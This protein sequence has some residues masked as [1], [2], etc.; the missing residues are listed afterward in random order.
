[1][2]KFALGI[3][4]VFILLGGVL[5]AA[6]ERKISLT[7]LTDEEIV[8]FTND[9]QAENYGSDEIEVQLENST[10]GV[11]AEIVR[12]NDVINP[13]TVRSLGDNRYAI[14]VS[15][16]ENKNSGEAEVK[17][18]ARDDDSQSV[19]VYVQVNTIIESLTRKSDDNVDAR[20]N[21]F[22]VKGVEKRLVLEDYFV[23][24]PE[25]ANVYNIDWTI[26]D[27]N[28]N[29][30]KQLL[31]EDVVLAEIQNDR[32]LVNA[33]YGLS[34]ITIRA[35]ET[36]KGETETVDFE[37]LEN[38]TINE[39]YMDDAGELVYLYQNNNRLTDQ[40]GFELVRNE[41]NLSSVSGR[42]RVNTP[43]Q[44][45][46]QPLVYG[47]NTNG[48]LEMVSN[49]LDYFSFTI[50]NT[51]DQDG[52]VVYDFL[53]DA[54]DSTYTKNV[55]GE[56]VLF[57]RVG[58]V[59][60]N[61]DVMTGSFNE[62]GTIDGV[63]INLDVY[64][65][66]TGIDL[67]NQE[68]NIINN[69]SID[70]FSD[71]VDGNGYRIV[72]TLTP[73][74][75][76][77]EGKEFYISVNLNQ[78]SLDLLN[79]NLAGSDENPIDAFAR[80]YYRNRL[81]EFNP[82]EQGSEVYVTTPI[83]DGSTIYVL[84]SAEMFEVLNDVTFEFVSTG[85]S[86]AKTQV[87]MNFYEVSDQ[88]TL[89][90]NFMNEDE[91]S[92]ETTVFLP[93]DMQSERTQ[94][95]RVRIDGISTISG[96]TLQTDENSY[97]QFSDLRVVDS[98]NN[99][100]ET[101]VI[102]EFDVTLNGY[103]FDDYT[104]FWFE[105]I[106]GRTSDPLTIQAF[107][108]LD[109]VFV[110]N[111]EP[112][113]ADV[114]KSETAS[115]DFVLQDDGTI[116]TNADY[117]NTSLSKLMME[118]GAMLALNFDHDNA[119]LAE[120][121]SF[122][123]LPFQAD[124]GNDFVSA[125][126]FINQIGDDEEALALAEQMFADNNLSEIVS[127]YFQYF[128]NLNELGENYFTIIDGNLSL[129]DKEFKGFL[130]VVFSGYNHA[131]EQVSVVRFFALE[132]FYS[133]RYL[134]SS[135][136]ATELY[137]S[138]T[139]SYLDMG[140]SQVNVRIELRPDE[141]IPT[142]SNDLSF[143]S[144]KSVYAGENY[145]GVDFYFENGNAD[146][147]FTPTTEQDRTNN[148][149]YTLSA[150]SFSGSGRYLNFTITANSTNMQTQVRD[151]LRIVYRDANGFE[152]ETE[153][154]ISIKNV[155]RIESVECSDTEVY[156]NLTSSQES[157]RSYTITTILSPSDANDSGLTY[158]Y[159]AIGG[160][161]ND[162]AITTSSMGQTFSLNI[163]TDTASYG[164]L[165]L[166]PNDMIKRYGTGNHILLYKYTED[167]NGKIVETALYR[168]LSDLP[169]LYDALVADE[170]NEEF[171]V[172]FLNND[173][174]KIYYKDIV[175]RI[176]VT[177]ADGSS[178]GTAIRVYSEQ[179][180]RNIDYAKY[181]Q[182]MNNITLS[183]WETLSAHNFSGMLFGND[184][185][186][187]LTFTNNSQVFMDT[188]DQRGVIRDLTFAGTV[189][190]TT[191]QTNGGFVAR[192]NNGLIENVTIDVY[193][194]RMTESYLGST[195]S[196]S[197]TNVGGIVG[198]NN[199]TL[200]DCNVF[201]LN[202][203]ASFASNNY[204]GGLA[205]I[206]YN[207]IQGSGVEFYNFENGESNKFVSNGN[208]GIAGGLAGYAETG[209]SISGSYVYAYSLADKTGDYSSS[210]VMSANLYRGAFVGSTRGGDTV[211]E[212]FAFVGDLTAPF[213]VASSGT[214]SNYIN[215]YISYINGG[216][217]YSRIFDN[218]TFAY[219]SGQ[220]FGS[221]LDYELM[222][223]ADL[224][225]EELT[226][227]KRNFIDSLPIDVW[228]ING[229]DDVNFGFMYLTNTTQTMATDV[230][231]LTV[232]DNTSPMKS[233]YV[234]ANQGILFVYRTTTNISDSAQNSVLTNL[235]TLS[236]AD[237]FGITDEQA[238]SLLLT[239]DSTN[240]VFDANYIRV[241]SRTTTPF[242]VEIHSKM[243]YSVSKTFQFVILNNLPQLSLSI[244]GL[245]LGNNQT[246]MLQKGDLNTRNVVTYLDSSIY[247]SGNPNPYQTQQD[248]YTV[249][250]DVQNGNASDS[251]TYVRVIK[252]GNNLSLTG[253]NNHSGNDV[254]YVNPYVTVEGLADEYVQALK[255]QTERSFGVSVYNG[256]TSLTI[257]DASDLTVK[258]A[259][260]AGFEVV[261][262][263]DNA[264]DNLVFTLDYHLDGQTI[265]ITDEDLTD[266][267]AQF[268]VD[269]SL[270]LEVS[271]TKE[272][273]AESENNYSF[274]SIISVSRE[275]R[276]LVNK[277]YN[278]TLRINSYS[279]RN[280]LDF[281]KSIEF[282]VVP[283][284][285]NAIGISVYEIESTQIRNSIVY[286]VPSN[287]VTNVLSPSS[288]AILAVT[289][290]PAYA[291]ASRFTLTYT[292][293]GSGEVGTVSIARLLFNA[294]Y[295][296]YVNTTST[297]LIQNGIEVQLTEQDKTGDGVYYFRIRISGAFNTNSD[298]RFNVTYYNGST[299]LKSVDKS[300]NVDYVQ[301]ADIKVNGVSTYLMPRGSQATVTVQIGLDQQLTEF[302]L[303]GNSA[304]ISLVWNRTPEIYS[305]YQIYTATLTA[306]VNATLANGK[307]NGVFYVN[308]TVVSTTGL[309]QTPKTSFATVCLVDF[310]VDANNITVASSGGTAVYNGNTYDVFYSYIGDT[311][312]LRFDYPLLPEEYIYN[313]TNVDEVQK[314]EE[315]ERKKIDFLNTNSYIDEDAEYY[316]NYRRNS[317]T[318]QYEQLTLK[319]QLWYASSE[320]SS[321]T[322]FN[323]T[324]IIQNDRF[325]I[326]EQNGDLM[327][328]GQRTGRQLM[329]LQTIVS[330]QGIEFVY[331][332][333]FLIVV[334]VW[335]D[336]EAPTQITTGA[337]F[338]EFATLSEQ[339]DDYIL[340]N[341][342][343]LNE[344]TPINT[345]LI[346]S[347][348]GNGFTI[349]INSFAMPEGNA[350]NLA[351]FNEVTENTTLKNVRVNVHQGGHINVDVSAATGYSTINI[352]G[353]ALT[354]NGIIYNCEVV[355]YYDQE[356]QTVQYSTNGIVVT[357]TLGANTDPINLTS[358]MGVTSMVSGFVGTNN[359]S[360]MNSRV[361]G[362]SFRHVVDIGGRDYL[363]TQQ[364]DVFVLDG[365]GEVAGFV[366][367]NG[368]TVVS[369]ETGV[370]D[371]T[372]YISAS[373]VDN[374]QIYNRMEATTSTTAGFVLYNFNNI[375]GSYIEGQGEAAEVYKNLTNIT[376]MGIV[377][378][379]VYSND[380]LV[381][382]SYAN[383]AIENSSSRTALSA[384]FVYMNN[385]TGEVT[386]CYAACDIS[387]LDISE[388][389]FSG[390]NEDLDSLNL[391]TISFCYYYNQTREELT[392][393]DRIGSGA[394]PVSDHNQDTFY[395]FNFASGD[396]T[397]DGIWKNTENGITLVSANTIALSNRNPVVTNNV[398]SFFYSRSIADA[399]TLVT[400]DLSYGSENN[401]IIIR[402]AEEFAMATGRATDTEISSYKEYYN[403]DEVFGNYRL[404]NNI[405]LSEIDQNAENEGFV[406]LRTT[407][408]TFSGLL[409]G[410]G[411]SVLNLNLGSSN[412]TESYGLFARLENAVIMNIDFT[413]DTVHNR[414]ANVVGALAG[415]AID[416]RLLSINV[417]PVGNQSS[418]NTY[419]FGS[420]VVGG[421][422]GMIFGQSKMHD[423]NVRDIEIYSSYNGQEFNE[424]DS[425]VGQPLR[426]FI[427]R[428]NILESKI[429]RISY[430]GAIAGYVDIY[431]QLNSDY[432]KFNQ[433]L[434]V[435]DFNVVTV[436]VEDAIDI[437]GG[438]AGGLFGYVG[439][440]TLIYDAGIEL[441]A[442]MNLKRPSY[443]ISRNL[444]AGGLIGENYG[445]L[446]AVYARYEDELQ[447]TIE[448]G[449][450]GYYNGKLNAEKGQQSIFS[451]TPNDADY[452]TNTNDPMFV[453]GLVGYMGGGYIYVGYNK[454]NVI[455]HSDNTYAVGGVIGFAA[456]NS[457]QFELNF[458]TSQP[459][460]NILLYDVY[461]SGDVYADGKNAV[462]AGIVGAMENNGGSTVLMGM[463]DV[464]AVNYYTY[465]G[466]RFSGDN[467]GSTVSSGSYQGEYLSDRHFTVIG[468]IL[469][470]SSVNEETQRFDTVQILNTNLY[471]ISS[472]DSMF[473]VLQATSTST[474]ADAGS[475][476]VGGYTR[477]LVGQTGLNLNPYG[478]GVSWSGNRSIYSNILRVDSIGDANSSTMPAAYARMSTYF[479]PIGWTDDYWTHEENKL[480]PE[481]ELLPTLDILYWDVK[482]T[483]DG[484][485]DVE[486]QQSMINQIQQNPFIT[487]VL[488]G[489]V[490]YESPEEAGTIC[491]DIDL[492]GVDFDPIENFSGTLISYYEYTNTN[493][494]GTVSASEMS[495]YPGGAKVS[496][497]NV[498][499]I[500]DQPLFSNLSEGAIIQGVKFYL[501][502]GQNTINFS[503]VE[504]SAVMTI[505]RND[506]IILNNNVSLK[507]RT[508]DNNEYAGLLVPRAEDTSIV[509]LQVKF[510]ASE[511]GSRVD[512]FNITA[513]S[514]ASG[515]SNLYFGAIVG[516]N[517]QGSSTT[518]VSM[519]QIDFVL[520][521]EED[522]E[523]YSTQNQTLSPININFNYG[524]NFASA[525]G[526]L[527]AG[528]V[529]KIGGSSRISMGL[530]RVD[531][532][533]LNISTDTN[534]TG[535]NGYFGG[536][537]GS[538]SSLDSLTYSAE[539][540][541]EG[542]LTSGITV[543]QNS[544]FENLY[545]GL[546][547]GEIDSSTINI[548]N[549]NARDAI[550]K[551]SIYQAN[552]VS[553]GLAQIGGIA[554]SVSNGSIITVQGFSIDLNVSKA[555]EIDETYTNEFE[556]V[557]TAYGNLKPYQVTGA[558]ANFGGFF[559]SVNN[560]QTTISGT[561]NVTGYVDVESDNNDV[562]FA[563]GGF[564]GTM[565]GILT[566]NVNSENTLNISIKTAED[567]TSAQ[568]ANVGG[569][570]GN[571]TSESNPIS[572]N[573]SGARFIYTGNVL[574][575]AKTLNFGG[576]IGNIAQRQS[577]TDSNQAVSINNTAFGGSVSVYGANIDGG[578]L[579][580]GGVVGRFNDNL[581]GGKDPNTVF[582]ISNC[583]SYG[584]VFVNY[585]QNNGTNNFDW[586]LAN[587][588]FGGIV[589][590]ATKMT[591][592]NCYSL[593]TSFNSKTTF[594]QS[595][596]GNQYN[597]GAIVGTNAEIVNYSQNYYSSGV[598]M[599]YQTDILTDESLSD[600]NI[601]SFYGFSENY[602]ED[603]Y[604]YSS[605]ANGVTEGIAILDAFE[606]FVGNVGEV[607]SKLNPLDYNGNTITSSAY[608]LVQRTS[609]EQ[610]AG[611]NEYS[612]GG[613]SNSISWVML[614]ADKTIDDVISES[615]QNI[616]FVGNGYTLTRQDNKLSS[617][618]YEKPENYN[619]VYARGGIVNE[620][621]GNFSM[622]SS[623]VTDLDIVADINDNNGVNAYG[624][625]AG[626]TSGNAFIYATGVEGR[627]SVG[628]TSQLRLGGIVGLMNS[629]FINESYTD[630]NIT[631]RAAE[632]GYVSG[633]ANLQGYN[634]ILSTYS[635][636][637]I[638]TYINVPVYTFAYAQSNGG[639]TSGTETSYR[640]N[641]LA[642]CYSY[643]TVV[644][645]ET[646]N[647]QDKL[648][649]FIN[650]NL[651][652]DGSNQV[653]S[654][655]GQVFN[656]SYDVNAFV[657][658]NKTL[659]VANDMALSYNGI[660]VADVKI[661]ANLE[662]DENN[663]SLTTWYFS[664]YTN[665]GYASHGFAFLKN[666]TA[667]SRTK[668]ET[669]EDAEETARVVQTYNYSPVDYAMV[670]ETEDKTGFYL[671]V[672]NAGKFE[673]LVSS[674]P[675]TT[676]DEMLL[677]FVL[678]HDI[679]MQKF[680]TVS[681]GQTVKF[682]TLDGNNRTL[683]FENA[684]S[685]TFGLFRDL[686]GNV[687]N[688][689]ITNY[690]TNN[691]TSD[692]GTLATTMTGNL[693][694][695]TVTGD[696]TTRGNVAGGVVGTLNGNA[697]GVEALVNI[698]SS[699]SSS[700][701]GGVVGRLES[702]IVSHSSNSG[703]LVNESDNGSVGVQ[704]TVKSVSNQGNVTED[705]TAITGGVVGLAN[706]GT[707]IIDS[708]NAN[709]VLSGFTTSDETNNVAGGVVGYSSG[710]TISNSYNTG[711][712]GAGNYSGSGKNFAGGIVGYGTASTNISN[713]ANDA[714]VEALGSMNSGNY[715]LTVGEPVGS[716]NQSA[717]K[718]PGSLTYTYTM[719]YNLN[720]ERQV[721]AYG[722]GFLGAESGDGSISDSY[723]STENIKNDGNIGQYVEEQ[724]MTF[725]RQAVLDND[726]GDL[727]FYGS[728][729]V[730][731]DTYVNGYD[732]Y[733][734]PARIY[735]T[736]TITRTYGH[737]DTA[738]STV[739][740]QRAALAEENSIAAV[741]NDA[742]YEGAY[743]WEGRFYA[744]VNVKNGTY[745]PT[746]KS[747]AAG[748]YIRP[749]LQ[750]LLLAQTTDY[751]ASVEFSGYDEV[752]KDETTIG[753][754]GYVSTSN[755]EVI[756]N[757]SEIDV[758]GN[759][760]NINQALEDYSGA[761][762]QTTIAGEI[763]GIVRSGDNML[764][765][766]APIQ[767]T[768][769]VTINC[770]TIN[771]DIDSLT[772]D[773]F[774]ISVEELTQPQITQINSFL[775]SGNE[776]EIEFTL[777]FAT[778]PGYSTVDITVNYTTKPQSVLLGKNNVIDENGNYKI[779]LEDDYGSYLNSSYFVEG[780]PQENWVYGLLGTYQSQV[781]AS[782]ESA[783]V[784]LSGYS[785]NYSIEDGAYISINSN[786]FNSLLRELGVENLNGVN[787]QFMIS[788]NIQSNV[789]VYANV[790]NLNN[791]SVSGKVA[792][793]TP[794]NRTETFDGYEDSTLAG[795]GFLASD[796]VEG[797]YD[798]TFDLS[799]INNEIGDRGG[800]RIVFGDENYN[801]QYNGSGWIVG[802]NNVPNINLEI[803]GTTL[804]ITS[805]GGTSVNTFVTEMLNSQIYYNLKDDQITLGESLQG[806][807]ILS[808]DS[809][810]GVRSNYSAMSSD[811]RFTA[812]DETTFASYVDTDLT[813]DYNFESETG[814]TT[815]TFFGMNFYSID[816]E[817]SFT[818]TEDSAIDL[819]NTSGQP[820][821]FELSTAN[822]Y[823]MQS[824]LEAGGSIDISGLAGGTVDIDYHFDLD[825]TLQETN[826]SIVP[827]QDRYVVSDLLD[828][829]DSVIG[830][831]LDFAT[832]YP[833]GYDYTFTKGVEENPVTNTDET[834]FRTVKSYSIVESDGI[835]GTSYSSTY[836][837]FES[838]IVVVEYSNVTTTMTDTSQTDKI[839]I[840][841]VAKYIIDGSNI[842]QYK[843]PTTSTQSS[844]EQGFTYTRDTINWGNH[845]LDSNLQLANVMSFKEG[846][847]DPDLIIGYFDETTVVVTKPLGSTEY[848]SFSYLEEDN[849]EKV[850]VNITTQEIVNAILENQNVS[851]TQGLAKSETIDVSNRPYEFVDGTF[852]VSL[853]EN[854][855]Y[856]IQSPDIVG[857][858]EYTIS[859]DSYNEQ[860]YYYTWEAEYSQESTIEKSAQS[861]ELIDY[862]YIIFE[863]DFALEDEITFNSNNKFINGK[864]HNIKFSDN[865]SL[866]GTTEN[867]ILNLNIV[868]L[869][870][871]SVGVL[872]SD[873]AMAI[874][875]ASS[876]DIELKNLMLYGNMRNVSYRAN[877]VGSLMSQTTIT[878]KIENVV[879]HVSIVGD[880][881]R[882]NSGV[883]INDYFGKNYISQNL[884]ISGNGANGENGQDGQV[885]EN[886]SSLL[887]QNGG[888]GFSGGRIVVANNF[889]G[890]VRVGHAGYGGYGGNGGNGY[891]YGTSAQS[892]ALGGGGGGSYGANGQNRELEITTVAEIP[893]NN[894]PTTL[895]NRVICS[896]QFGGNGGIGGFGRIDTRMNNF[897]TSGTSGTA[898][899]ATSGDSGTN[900]A[901]SAS[902]MHTSGAGTTK[903]GTAFGSTD[904]LPFYRDG[905]ITFNNGI[906]MPWNVE[907]DTVYDAA[908][909]NL[910]EGNVMS[911]YGSVI[912]NGL[913]END[914]EKVYYY[915]HVDMDLHFIGGWKGE[916]S[917][918]V[919]WTNCD[920][921][922]SGGSFAASSEETVNV[923]IATS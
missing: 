335:S 776:V 747:E 510:R 653:I 894:S 312:E 727:P 32:L 429:S 763:T 102:V 359:A 277:T 556:A 647:A 772:K 287:E 240:V 716:E 751:Y 704:T 39:M 380:G 680:N 462:S 442:Y 775:P 527:Y 839:N 692:F 249:G 336:E 386:L 119:S 121:I 884:L 639:V 818:Q 44:V 179:D 498:G 227:S 726:N 917:R 672:N 202:I 9:E 162:L 479:L 871:L 108:P 807:Q 797:T 126:R 226:G 667:F 230:S 420:N 444:Y 824:F 370:M 350:L 79:Q 618:G 573:S 160:S 307:T 621:S 62:T 577:Q 805:T 589:G 562:S 241:V 129:L 399:D 68:G 752:L 182:I 686:T 696:A 872:Y 888:Y 53:I 145:N 545:A 615:L 843:S 393:E 445:G 43:Y 452:N 581:T 599:A 865:K 912:V 365:Q 424:Y 754:V 195:L 250:F 109:D 866:F 597:V 448:T 379:F 690:N 856:T 103:D 118:A 497:E 125:V 151:I 862:A 231:A 430:A 460:V 306:Y 516:L 651:Q 778:D 570:I 634:A 787:L 897:W 546:A 294:N 895:T 681:L 58:Y 65:I 770:D 656:A 900:G 610:T 511:T 418:A 296:Y 889:E 863:N 669:T 795:M 170:D 35:T 275:T 134:N 514:S 567:T 898:G 572:I 41:S 199:G 18:T 664:P 880:E 381:K 543:M 193:Y 773:D 678:T 104:N 21:L 571:Y 26:V 565:S 431:D 443:I 413:V 627:V 586:R 860:T 372:G 282:T 388:M 19:T 142:Y 70:V 883:T 481:I 827:G 436:H 390:V 616:A 66:A 211:R 10:A 731:A 737:I 95:Y 354:N 302:Y 273:I 326:D 366:Y 398:T 426:E 349:H 504:N 467:G 392:T 601:D 559:G 17:I 849:Q 919:I 624:G 243:D 648:N 833:E 489:K 810:L 529:E 550:L 387:R 899:G 796:F 146:G 602:N 697:T 881:I 557:K 210:N 817:F 153:I 11:R 157:E 161:S 266:N 654:T 896:E 340:M 4:S 904:I 174:E 137:T 794:T 412:P 215:S 216:Q 630:A 188:I 534:T 756:E 89:G 608:K 765:V 245:N 113:S 526:G 138:E 295:G 147:S 334:D 675:E 247:L 564:I 470:T 346:D 5:L 670:C 154:Q 300:L 93:S 339:P 641:Y 759:I 749:D 352:A 661:G 461:S 683:N 38:S 538:V 407:T 50:T 123:F 106:T 59:D 301:S 909:E 662:D 718:E 836:T 165:Y 505:F 285:I 587:Y 395:G 876:I 238:S 629:G 329:R 886:S 292:A 623:L 609:D 101:Y 30:V 77:I 566:S 42:I 495:K 633:V 224:P 105:H 428:D 451:Y 71:Y 297:S 484:Q 583:Y 831:Q 540:L 643:T 330:Y 733:G 88:E 159:D 363:K 221:I 60:Y 848:Y 830:Q 685:V 920:N 48:Q 265:E 205:G 171:S 110:S 584:D 637:Q 524:S 508:I 422:V 555:N 842:H 417:S 828:E 61:Y 189:N 56:F 258:P 22:A 793:E 729:Q 288:D 687:E 466:A 367:S 766:C 124:N 783:S 852:S 6:C 200:R 303:S 531:N 98:Q 135:V 525:H 278:F 150:I 740:A 368:T 86:N 33:N 343:V 757:S 563:A 522:Q 270:V 236:I 853:Q 355:S 907:S 549:N 728:F 768:G 691:V 416:S 383:I 619:G 51:D 668:A 198:A 753:L 469:N 561:C 750:D 284:D 700:I 234:S 655:F 311:Q 274:K 788:S 476:T 316:I 840:A 720:D 115:Q 318:G 411:F 345:D 579:T 764:A 143:F 829:D 769:T 841:D 92:A 299:L 745:A 332:Y 735:R 719:T 542:E 439:N 131:H 286:L 158:F 755:N 36:T 385:E 362:E 186:I 582:E 403:D 371:G 483:A 446:F 432:V 357:Y 304:N 496:G 901:S 389:L 24:N 741:T 712:V 490:F 72:G 112:S 248:E 187:T 748:R 337:E 500:L 724:T 447:D 698:T 855:G 819:V 31:D 308:A 834:Y 184:P 222:T 419:V 338:V 832:N 233:L 802:A 391:G 507:S 257:T 132:S 421:V 455:S 204:L 130:A 918:K 290:D 396:E 699:G 471:L 487:V 674:A 631:Y 141:K 739:A 29:S 353:F 908:V 812:G 502:N 854:S 63:A 595:I 730:G 309:N 851:L 78:T 554:G 646:N 606:D 879:S 798:R 20:T 219:S 864:G 799:Q 694:N 499:L 844:T 846:L 464:L 341:D 57:L 155:K 725:D 100:D 402:N 1:M 384:G 456:T 891:F 887:G 191:N 875:G 486:Y 869:M 401:P 223:E 414:Q 742:D 689:R 890:I 923:S 465:D 710:A 760:S 780:D 789:N 190:D 874:D 761:L 185:S 717:T 305:T 568:T 128:Q 671:G 707:T 693:S 73:N 328:T 547:F 663:Q 458:I 521:D 485:L 603:Y 409:D 166:L 169:S 548:S 281:E 415:I 503:V 298:L 644:R 324:S 803:S 315:L 847:S 394:L 786:V 804:T 267:Q 528:R 762:E 317:E 591:V 272:Q 800:S 262:A 721:F 156:L 815:H 820:L 594:G 192:V 209:S 7:L 410:N 673:Q 708:Y 598:T 197:A 206:N 858:T 703:M 459:Q 916:Q 625:I 220:Y 438:V 117:Q 15:S 320:T 551:G 767:Y 96:L 821:A 344:Y 574:S 180:L 408:K 922:N 911:K 649:Y 457:T 722:I 213:V 515:S 501:Y 580:A 235:N 289:V 342:I 212:S 427:E 140:R 885:T 682:A 49:Y 293:T 283:Q 14:S 488:R 172:Y 596:N 823:Y 921:I 27:G 792:G 845:E 164:Y 437:Y 711:F 325:L 541:R 358:T 55:Y 84:A 136:D 133:I 870:D 242:E 425:F 659:N 67:T 252:S 253:I 902:W 85:N 822:G 635:G 406:Q 736:D 560:S 382:N 404:V 472:D 13:P 519:Q 746:A 314:V 809:N 585:L 127:D 376:S 790:D 183:G 645:T 76:D 539:E 83:L 477:V 377:A 405:D 617:E 181:Y 910:Y 628:G 695:V 605:K 237:L 331:D 47:R 552:G 276:H 701:L 826:L 260:S 913:I 207:I 825:Y 715:S 364:L 491:T 397:Y 784:D 837:I 168:P 214:T 203:T 423:I 139:L 677:N 225:F 676:S 482:Y 636:G 480:F 474:T 246:I 263:T 356:Y 111:N 440:S 666:S 915:S 81:L 660:S 16:K 575:N 882:N 590:C 816:V 177:I 914:Y 544:S 578:N 373:F 850:N 453:G 640:T 271:W 611:E 612:I 25:T 665:Y 520:L 360:I 813:N 208:S 903:E 517:S 348:D 537:V 801:I 893:I 178:E 45:T 269:E 255:A 493:A 323:G 513:N 114:F 782:T 702:G 512:T 535:D 558:T 12:G 8:I 3:L 658:D 313:N 454:L 600:T 774:E 588:N 473:N 228:T 814:L 34:S 2:K 435:S 523:I 743:G 705:I 607:G 811:N 87:V 279:Q 873:I 785:I 173:G 378:G 97:F 375:Q 688:L 450:N 107:V 569:M 714:Q 684:S 74:T 347:L 268:L 604:G 144:F 777:Y 37:I 82:R 905:K 652:D 892:R 321:S 509:N 626:K 614:S 244:G 433:T 264:Q 835:S 518:Q 80:F 54:L 229:N 176:S 322:I 280:N 468:N 116:G 475:Y 99:D 723:S 494:M 310:A 23:V 369:D 75:V 28:G 906:R 90:A 576:V 261:M 175:K 194:D 533:V 650:T 122:R 738:L 779:K 218:K 254:T 256:A 259:Q 706:A 327:I 744:Y 201:G 148:E 94:T 806:G 291:N 91:I 217:V 64:Y 781:S 434:Q 251:Q 530:S 239:S 861:E 867:S 838:G 374:V 506:E 868:G 478:F 167:E 46:L 877:A 622:I 679:D 149:Y 52:A 232:N 69:T 120:E 734:M 592:Q 441:N 808:L 400:Y 638:E 857:G 709:A 620:M 319:Q 40:V 593:M 758:D 657:D 333:Y 732:S 492:T 463:K 163:N 642:N 196:S 632:N 449:E 859:A 613:N 351:L 791:N 361:G 713:C 553:T 771:A 536:Y 878:P 152:K 532:V